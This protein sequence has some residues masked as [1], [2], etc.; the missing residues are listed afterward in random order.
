MNLSISFKESIAFRIIWLL[1]NPHSRANNL[2]FLEKN[3]AVFK[4]RFC[5]SFIVLP[6]EGK[7][8][9]ILK[10]SKNISIEEYFFP[11]LRL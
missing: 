7:L 9:C 10:L 2:C 1:V 8:P 6:R 5:C 4:T 3:L 11:G